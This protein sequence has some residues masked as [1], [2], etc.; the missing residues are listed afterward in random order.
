M[1]E[2][3]EIGKIV[4]THGIKGELRIL[5]NFEKKSVIF[6]AGF[7]IYIGNEKRKEIINSYR[8]HKNFEMICY[9]NVSNINE[10]LQDKGK[11]VFIKRKDLNLKAEEYLLT[12]ILGYNVVEEGKKIGKIV[13][14]VYNK[15]SI[16]LEIK[17]ETKKFYIPKN[18]N[19]IKK[20]DLQLKIVYT[21]NAKGLI[22]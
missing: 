3:I 1:N 16:L 19:F 2:W 10:V 20:V 8:H 21:E 22:L 13:D 18:E 9:E 7:E 15:A 5:S 17:G 11:K 4:N 14:F 6:R 12:D